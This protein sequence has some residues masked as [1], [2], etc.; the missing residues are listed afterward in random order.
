MTTSTFR[1]GDTLIHRIVELDA[2]SSPALEF[3]PALT[4]AQLA[5]SRDWLKRQAAL[6]D[7]DRVL[8]C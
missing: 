3:L 4:P 7:E 2:P 6:D 5:E 8:M 1:I